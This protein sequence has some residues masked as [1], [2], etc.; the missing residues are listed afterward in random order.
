MK[1]PSD[2]YYVAEPG[3]TAPVLF[4][5]AAQLGLRANDNIDGLAVKDGGTSAPSTRPTSSTSR[6]TSRRPRVRPSRAAAKGILQ[7]RPGPLQVAIPFTKLDVTAAPTEEIDAI[8][9]Y[10]PGDAKLELL[11]ALPATR[12]VCSPASSSPRACPS[13]TTSVPTPGSI[14]NRAYFTTL[15]D[16]LDAEPPSQLAIA[17]KFL[18][19]SD[20]HVVK[21]GLHPYDRGTS[22]IDTT[23]DQQSF[24][25]LGWVGPGFTDTTVITEGDP[26]PGTAFAMRQ[27]N[28]CGTSI[29]GNRPCFF[30]TMLDNSFQ[31]F[32]SA[33][34]RDGFGLWTQGATF[35]SQGT[36][37][38]ART[39][40]GLNTFDCAPDVAV[41]NLTNCYGTATTSTNERVVLRIQ[42]TPS[43]AGPVWSAPTI[44]LDGATPAPGGGFFNDYGFQTAVQSVV[45]HGRTTTGGEGIYRFADGVVTRIADRTTPVP[46]GTGTFRASTMPSRTTRARS[47]F[48]GLSAGGRGVYTDLTGRLHKI[49]QVGDVIGG[50]TVSN[51]SVTR[52]GASRSNVAVAVRF[53][54]GWES[55]LVKELPLPFDTADATSAS[56]HVDVELDPD[57]TMLGPDPR[58]LLVGDLGTAR[59]RGIWTSNGTTG[60][61]KIPGS[62]VERLAGAAVRRDTE[63]PVSRSG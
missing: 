44:V 11:T 26:I 41:A 12:S 2:V 53:D 30:A 38:G 54:D 63:R 16:G 40:S 1:A 51:V 32:W 34:C 28:R 52:D 21:G 22:L 59:L 56:V 9:G 14:D 25:Y 60:R 43:M 15:S 49:V 48:V 17:A 46:G 13:A 62:E 27:F 29:V 58:S 7:V 42:A 24:H 23:N 47:R 8:T 6:S 4:A 50:R 57:P 20:L 61:I 36:V 10:D 37:I 19:D 5:T 35:M 3:I 55:I 33:L 31:P 39:I 18:F 45:F